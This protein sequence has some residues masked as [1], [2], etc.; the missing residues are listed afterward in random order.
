MVSSILG[1]QSYFIRNRH[2]NMSKHGGEGRFKRH[3]RSAHSL[4]QY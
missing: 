3:W 4:N 2:G 1:K